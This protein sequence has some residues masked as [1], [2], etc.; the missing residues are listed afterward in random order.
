M[1]TFPTGRREVGSLEFIDS[2]LL[3]AL[4]RTDL[5]ILDDWGLE[6]A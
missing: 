2:R 4:G 1:E 3:R 5:L 6:Q